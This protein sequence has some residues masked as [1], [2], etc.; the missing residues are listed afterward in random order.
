MAS[1]LP[2]F[3]SE[4]EIDKIGKKTACRL[5]EEDVVNEL[6][7]KYQYIFLIDRSGSMGM[8]NRMKITNDA[9]ILFL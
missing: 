6:E 5:D 1:F 4:S 7:T 9:I 2:T 3:T 8:K